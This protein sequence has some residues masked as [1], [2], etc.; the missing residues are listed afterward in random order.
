M[1]LTL[2]VCIL[3]VFHFFGTVAAQCDLPPYTAAFDQIN[4]DVGLGSLYCSLPL[5]NYQSLTELVIKE[6]F[7]A[8]EGGSPSFFEDCFAGILGGFVSGLSNT[9]MACAPDEVA[10]STTFD[11]SNANE[12]FWTEYFANCNCGLNATELGTL[13]TVQLGGGDIFCINF[14]K[15]NY[16][17][18]NAFYKRAAKEIAY[19]IDISG[20][21]ESSGYN[22][23]LD[24]STEVLNH[25]L[26]T[27]GCEESVSAYGTIGNVP[28]CNR[29]E[30]T[31]DN[32]LSM[33]VTI[34]SDE[35]FK[36]HACIDHCGHM[37][38]ENLNEYL[39]KYSDGIGLS[40]NRY[41]ANFDSV[42]TL[43][44][45]EEEFDYTTDCTVDAENERAGRCYDSAVKLASKKKGHK[46]PKMQKKKN[47][48]KGSRKR[49]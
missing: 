34:D 21:F 12:T 19:Y 13:P 29:T 33:E 39:V 47:A 32:I 49:L 1:K 10:I 5:P 42:V 41:C 23:L 24:P 45:T 48:K 2:A 7:A 30:F 6:G 46:G 37:S 8:V 28:F 40:E 44:F 18:L 17:V 27:E 11:V 9:P 38:S 20:K 36:S 25:F 14:N 4:P 15:C 43:E 16:D 22:P 3:R 31:C 26:L 35:P